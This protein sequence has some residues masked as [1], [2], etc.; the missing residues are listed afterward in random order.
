MGASNLEDIISDQVND[1]LRDRYDLKLLE[2]GCGSASYFRF[3]HLGRTIGIDISPEQLEHNEVLQEKIQGDLQTYPLPGNAFDIVVCWDVIEH[4]SRPRD[5]LLNM[6][7]SLR[8]GG[9]LVLGFPNLLSF[10]GLA[11]KITPYWFHEVFYRWMKYKTRHFPTYLRLSILPNR[12]IDFAQQNG[13]E[14][15]FH[16]LLEGGVTTRFKQRFWFVRTLFA[17][18]DAGVRAISFGRCQSL[19]LDNCALILKKRAPG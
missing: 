11:T 16:R 19:Y 3:R 8:P 18:L 7:R 12:V 9:V 2:A 13:F 6:F 15:A 14:V 1:L 5:A 4:L 10:K 17:A